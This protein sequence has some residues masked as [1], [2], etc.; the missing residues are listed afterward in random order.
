MERLDKLI[1]SCSTKGDDPLFKGT[2][3]MSFTFMCP[4]GCQQKPGEVIGAMIY[5]ISSSL[6]LSAIHSGFLLPSGGTATIMIA[7]G[8]NEYIPLLQNE[9]QS[10]E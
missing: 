2:T 1:V 10:V 5:E 6:C 7:N 9:I 3:G 8:E 4:N